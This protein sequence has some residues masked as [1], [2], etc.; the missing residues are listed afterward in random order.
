MT[1]HVTQRHPKGTE[2]SLN[3]SLKTFK[4]YGKMTGHLAQRHTKCMES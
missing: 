2:S 1:G 3:M 4:R